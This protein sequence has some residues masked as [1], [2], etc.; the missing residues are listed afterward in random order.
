LYEKF[1][2]R[3][4]DNRVL[5]RMLELKDTGSNMRWRNLH[6]EELVIF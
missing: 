2:L 1:G 4:L 5:R 3:M 6:N